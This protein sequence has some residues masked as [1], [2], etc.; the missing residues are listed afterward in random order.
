[1]AGS[2]SG[3]GSSHR[4]DIIA[5]KAVEASLKGG[6]MLALLQSFLVS[7]M[8]YG[9]VSLPVTAVFYYMFFRHPWMRELATNPTGNVFVNHWFFVWACLYVGSLVLQLGMMYDFTDEGENKDAHT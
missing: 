7:M 2:D 5:G 8:T 6:C 4:G 3:S 9:V 1:M